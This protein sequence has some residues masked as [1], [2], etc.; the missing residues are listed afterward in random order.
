MDI[1]VHYKITSPDLTRD[2]ASRIV[3]LAVN[4]YCSVAATINE[5]TE[6]THGFEI[7]VP[8]P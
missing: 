2:E 4:K 5:S 6:L 3:D 1:H 7:E 8:K